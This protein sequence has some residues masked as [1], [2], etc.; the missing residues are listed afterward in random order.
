MGRKGN[1]PLHELPL[2]TSELPGRAGCEVRMSV[3]SFPSSTHPFSLSL[4]PL[5]A[6][7][8]GLPIKEKPEPVCFQTFASAKAGSEKG[9]SSGRA[10]PDPSQNSHSS[11]PHAHLGWYNLYCCSFPVPHVGPPCVNHGDYC[12]ETLKF[13]RVPSCSCSRTEHTTSPCRGFR[14]KSQIRQRV[15]FVGHSFI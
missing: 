5:S 12:R 11:Q 3:C 13:V 15:N 8:V 1:F 7:P 2:C 6:T 4:R 10:G 14:T 9:V